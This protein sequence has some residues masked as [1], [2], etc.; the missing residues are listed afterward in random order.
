MMERNVEYEG[1]VGDEKYAWQKKMA[2]FSTS[3]SPPEDFF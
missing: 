2:H 3:G 1:V